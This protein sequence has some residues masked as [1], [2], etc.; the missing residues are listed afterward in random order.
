MILKIHSC[1]K[2]GRTDRCGTHHPWLATVVRDHASCAF[3]CQFL[4]DTGSERQALP[5]GRPSTVTQQRIER[6]KL[7][8]RPRADLELAA[9]VVGYRLFRMSPGDVQ[10]LR[11]RPG[12]VPEGWQRVPPSLL[13]YADEQTVA[14]TAAVFTAMEAMATPPERFHNWGVV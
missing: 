11:R 1:A 2:V 10:A 13:R 3:V 4:P 9:S 14:G 6:S 5:K 7:M 12:P 8:A